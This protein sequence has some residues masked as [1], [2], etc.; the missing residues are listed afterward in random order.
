[1]IVCQNALRMFCG[2][3]HPGHVRTTS[4]VVS[5]LEI[6]KELFV[7]TW[8]DVVKKVILKVRQIY[9]SLWIP[10]ESGPKPDKFVPPCGS[11]AIVDLSLTDLSLLVDPR[12]GWG[13]IHLFLNIQIQIHHFQSNTNTNTL[14]FLYDSNTLSERNQIQIRIWPQAWSQAMVISSLT[15]LALLVEPRRW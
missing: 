3:F 5:I 4:W 2:L 8:K 6:K 12:Q 13:Q 14:L 7:R 11:Q 15:N 1:M 9:L 10:A